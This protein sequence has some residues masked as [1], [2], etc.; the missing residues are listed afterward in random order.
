MHNTYAQISLG[1]PYVDQSDRK[2][3]ILF[4]IKRLC[5]NDYNLNVEM[6]QS[7]T[8]TLRENGARTGPREV[9]KSWQYNL[10]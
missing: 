4:I 9:M 7:I 8:S 3:C 2:I 6:E 1:K 5:L 10:N